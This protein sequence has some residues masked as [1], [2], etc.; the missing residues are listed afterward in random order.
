MFFAYWK[1][2]VLKPKKDF[3]YENNVQNT[4]KAERVGQRYLTCSIFIKEMVTVY[5]IM[6]SV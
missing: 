2:L 5:N 3:D 4:K 1:T 6:E